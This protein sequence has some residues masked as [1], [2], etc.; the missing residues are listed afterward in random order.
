[1]AELEARPGTPCR[2]TQYWRIR[3]FL[4]FLALLACSQSPIV[5][6]PG[7]PLRSLPFA[8]SNTDSPGLIRAALAGHADIYPTS[9]VV[10]VVADSVLSLVAK[11]DPTGGPDEIR[12]GL[13]SGDPRGSWRMDLKS[14]AVPLAALGGSRPF[15]MR[16]SVRFVI[17]EV[18]LSDLPSRWLV[19][20]LSSVL[21][22]QRT[23][24]PTGASNYLHVPIVL[25]VK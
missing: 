11:A 25:G 2:A 21:V 12:V 16:D 20:D 17:R 15:Q 18:R 23:R 1:M 5:R 4:P 3:R 14:D 19:F 9:M 6:Q 10:S 7:P 24:A 8:A 22:D 13:A